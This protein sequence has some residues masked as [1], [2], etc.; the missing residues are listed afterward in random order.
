MSF[1]SK[2]WTSRARGTT[3]SAGKSK[4]SRGP[5]ATLARIL[6]GSRAPDVKKVT[7]E[8]LFDSFAAKSER[9]LGGTE[10]P[11]AQLAD[12]SENLR[13]ADRFI[14]TQPLTT[15]VDSKGKR[16]RARI[17]NFSASG[18]AVEAD[19]TTIPRESVTHVG[20][21]RVLAG[22]QMRHGMVYLFEKPLDPDRCNPS[23]IL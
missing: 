8:L 15:L 6:G 22:R 19:F 21:M 3:S 10:G 11:E 20:S 7:H 1:A 5:R 18:V 13:Q 4:P 16:H 2:L 9:E 12:D 17:I 14:P 23:T